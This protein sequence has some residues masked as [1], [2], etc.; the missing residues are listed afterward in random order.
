MRHHEVPD[1][2]CWYKDQ[3]YDYIFEVVATDVSQNSIEIQHFAGEIEELDMESWFERDL[4]AI[5]PPEDWSGPYELSREDL[6][7]ADDALHPEDW[8]GPLSDIEPDE[9]Q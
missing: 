6:G 8:S 5:P 4:R 9:T 1:V 2:G 7:Y 3:E